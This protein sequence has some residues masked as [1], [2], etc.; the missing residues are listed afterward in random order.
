MSIQIKGANE[1]VAN[2]D[3]ITKE[4]RANLKQQIKTSAK[5][6]QAGARARCISPRVKTSIKIKFL[7]KGLTA[8]IKPT[9][10]YAKFIEFGTAPHTIQPKKKKI[11]S[12][13]GEAEG[14]AIFESANGK[15]VKKK[16]YKKT[17]GEYTLEKNTIFTPK[18]Q[19]PG[20]KASPFLFPAWEEE[21]PRFREG[22]IKAI[23]QVVE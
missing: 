22:I 5:N 2:I 15:Q 10:W 12:W 19:H 1:V 3:K 14:T 7:N 21:R 9:A 4:I 6:V 23:K 16:Y 20:I 8:Q 11:L 18:V 17:N 13:Q